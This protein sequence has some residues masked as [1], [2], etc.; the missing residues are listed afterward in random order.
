MPDEKIAVKGEKKLAWLVIQT[1]DAADEDGLWTDMAQ[2]DI[3]SWVTEDKCISKLAKGKMVCAD[4]E[5]KTK[6]YRA[7][8]VDE[9]VQH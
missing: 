4:P 5:K 1:S 6:W 9:P 8:H 7:V 3:P 2:A